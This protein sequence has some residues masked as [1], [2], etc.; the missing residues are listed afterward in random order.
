MSW[1]SYF[2]FIFTTMEPFYIKLKLCIELQDIKFSIYIFVDSNLLNKV[3]N[4][5]CIGVV[6]L[7]Y[8]T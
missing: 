4:F 2:N 3:I 5:R 8:L 1:D 6:W 7:Y